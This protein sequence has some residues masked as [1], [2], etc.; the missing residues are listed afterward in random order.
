[1]NLSFRGVAIATCIFCVSGALLWTVL[2]QLAAHFWETEP[3]H[4]SALISR[5]YAAVLFALATILYAAR[6]AEP[7]TARQAIS[8]GL[9]VGGIVMS[10]MSIGD[11]LTAEVGLAMLLAVALQTA[12]TACFIVLWHTERAAAAA[13]PSAS[14]DNSGAFPTR[15]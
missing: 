11:W 2:P 14:T 5:R 12:M 8:L 10:V 3:S 6:N 7:S 9:A 13:L 4:V 1:M 15:D